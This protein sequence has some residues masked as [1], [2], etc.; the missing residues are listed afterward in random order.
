[1]AAV[2]ERL[3]DLERLKQA[4]ENR[5]LDLADYSTSHFQD[6]EDLEDQIQTED[7][8]AAS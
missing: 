2:T 1:L 8:S 7:K 4:E 3:E 6:E 5:P